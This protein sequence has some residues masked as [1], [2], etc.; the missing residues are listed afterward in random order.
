MMIDSSQWTVVDREMTPLVNA[1]FGLKNALIE[2]D[3]TLANQQA[4]VLKAAG[5]SLVADSTL[6][7]A[8]RSQV[9]SIAAEADGFIG[10]QNLEQK[11]RAFSMMSQQLLPL[12]KEINYKAQPVYQQICPMAFN[13]T[14]T[15]YWLSG[16]REISN[17][18]LGKKHPKYASGMLHCGEL[19]DSLTRVP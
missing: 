16:E 18:Y 8:L 6:P 10:D 17:P 4:A 5:D 15:A 3:S 19:G 11:R 7:E 12:L 14:E 13:D 9:G 2:W 1:Y